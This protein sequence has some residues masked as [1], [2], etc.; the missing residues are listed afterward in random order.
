M[1]DE[2]RLFELVLSLVNSFKFAIVNEEIKHIM[3]ALQDPAVVNDE[4]RCN[5]IMKRYAEL[6]ES[7]RLMAKKLGDR[8]VLNG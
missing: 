3:H 2:E 8:V 6:R 5:S 7:Q 1:T 4:E